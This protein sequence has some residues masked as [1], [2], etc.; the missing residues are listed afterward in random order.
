MK[1]MVARAVVPSPRRAGSASPLRNGFD[2]PSTAGASAN[3]VELT[4]TNRTTSRTLEKRH[5]T[6]ITEVGRSGIG[7]FLLQIHPCARSEDR[8]MPPD[9]T[10]WAFPPPGGLQEARVDDSMER[11]ISLKPIATF[12][13]ISSGSRFLR[14]LDRHLRP[15]DPRQTT[16]EG[17]GAVPR[18]AEKS[19]DF[20]APG[21]IVRPQW[22][23]RIAW[24][25]AILLRSL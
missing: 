10:A 7:P 16:S 23:Q 12:R 21:R 24:I 11:G 25:W 4:T 19:F 18:N 1:I 14:S 13:I 6:E 15:G 3:S 22:T 20:G 8:F 17:R 2:G 5:A 9:N